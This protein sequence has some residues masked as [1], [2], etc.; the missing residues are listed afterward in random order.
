M[1]RKK[2]FILLICSILLVGMMFPNAV[3][4][5]KGSVVVTAENLNIREGPGLNYEVVAKAEHGKSYP[6][7]SE[8][9]DW[10]QIGLPSG[11]KGWIHKDYAQKE[12]DEFNQGGK[13]TAST[14]HVR[15]EP[16]SNSKS[17]GKLAKGDTV[18]ILSEKNEWLEISFQDGSGWIAGWYVEKKQTKAASSLP[19]EGF[20]TM[21]HDGTSIRSGPDLNSVVVERANSEDTF[22]IIG[23]HE[24]WYEIQ[25][26]S[27]EKG[28]VAGWIVSVSQ[29]VQQ[30]EKAGSKT[31]LKYKKIMIDPGHGGNDS[32]ATGIRGT[33][34]KEITMRTGQAIYNKLRAKGVHAILTRK[35]DQYLSLSTRASMAHYHD[36]DAF[37]SLH[38][39]S[40]DDHSVRG[41]TTYYYHDNQKELASAV[42]RSTIA[43]TGLKDRD[44]RFGDYHVIRENRHNSV[45]L[46]LGFISNPTEELI[47][48]T[49]QFQE[50]V[51][52]GV[53]RGLEDYFN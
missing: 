2:K 11:D 4:V 16:S 35:D 49:E 47:L 41:M 48:N 31:S 20:I 34:E 53:V 32:G 3:T 50:Q 1:F 22:P 24:D 38:Y 10:V 28:F 39:D 17:I 6:I 37:I 13:V 45:L 30:I 21:N 7:E 36:V 14:L 51:A 44:I 33:L 15:A 9:G 29:G 46:E 26:P 25:L 52:N 5:A 42:H 18:T 19:K 43:R 40:I 23:I 8:E 12:D 27:G